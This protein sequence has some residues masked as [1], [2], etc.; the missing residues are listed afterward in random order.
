MTN[1]GFPNDEERWEI[2]NP[3]SEIRNGKDL[4]SPLSTLI[5]SLSTP[6]SEY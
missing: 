5:S 6:L 2:R 3:K 1:E 4:S